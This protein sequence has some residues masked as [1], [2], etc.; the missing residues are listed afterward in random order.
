MAGTMCDPETRR[1]ILQ[2]AGELEADALAM[3]RERKVTN[4][5]DRA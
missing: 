1:L 5:Q 2:K 4:E 3:E